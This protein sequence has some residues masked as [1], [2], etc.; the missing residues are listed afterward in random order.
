MKVFSN[1]LKIASPIFI[2]VGVLHLLFGARADVMLGASIS[3]SSLIDPVLD[4]QNRFYGVTFTIYGFLLYLCSTNLKQYKNVLLIL[5]WV[6]FAAGL[7]RLVSI[8][9]VGVPSAPIMGLLVL[10]LIIPPTLHYW[11]T[12]V[13][14]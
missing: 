4:S 7:A 5:L 12:R 3:D 9:V 14:R 2:I 10:E 11:Y 6:F 8:S 13:V 1:A